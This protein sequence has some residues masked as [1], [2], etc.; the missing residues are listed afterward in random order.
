M[1]FYFRI[2]NC[3]CLLDY[4][5]DKIY[6]EDKLPQLSSQCI[7]KRLLHKLT[8]NTV[9]SFNGQ[10]YRQIDG[11]GMGNPLSPVLANIFMCKFE[12][13]VVIPSSPPFYDR[14][15]D[16]CFT[17]RSKS[18]PDTLLESLNTYHPNITFT[19]EENPT[20]FLDTEFQYKNGS[21]S[22]NVFKKPG[23]LPIHWSSQVP[24]SYKRNAILSALYRAKRIS[25][26]LTMELIKIRSTFTKAGYPFWFID[27]TFKEFLNPNEDESL[28]PTHWFDERKTIFIRLPY[29][30][31]NENESRKFIRKLSSFTQGYFKFKI[32]WSTRKIKSLFNLKD[33]VKHKAKVIYLGTCLDIYIYVCVCLCL[34]I[35]LRSH[36][37]L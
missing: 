7:F 26:N 32:L 18:Q 28:I 23:K 1:L 25:S 19:V 27:K 5:V 13:D 31:Q 37:I 11:C 20:H 8:Q 4:I 10:L 34:F 15:V 22:T 24:L 21:F 35:T 17:K 14:Y 6:R 30:R 16:D 12:E 29:C 2:S 36:Y 3:S 33:K 9:F